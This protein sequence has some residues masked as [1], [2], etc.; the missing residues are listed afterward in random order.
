MFW[1]VSQTVL[2]DIDGRFVN[3]SSL[4][5]VPHQATGSR[6]FVGS[7]PLWHPKSTHYLTSNSD[8]GHSDQQ[9]SLDE[10]EDEEDGQDEGVP[11]LYFHWDLLRRVPQ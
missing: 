9:P 4:F 10:I 2:I 7:S 6:F 8:S 1:S 3:S 5:P 11:L